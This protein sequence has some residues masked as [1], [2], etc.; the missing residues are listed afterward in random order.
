MWSRTRHY[1]IRT[2]CCQ[3]HIHCYQ[4]RT[5]CSLIKIVSRES[6]DY[7]LMGRGKMS[8][9]DESQSPTQSHFQS[10]QSH[11]SYC[12]C[13][14]R[15]HSYPQKTCLSP[16][17]SSSCHCCCCS[18]CCSRGAGHQNQI[19]NRLQ[20]TG[21]CRRN[22]HGAR[23]SHSCCYH[24]SRGLPRKSRSSRG[25]QT[26]CRALGRKSCC[27]RSPWCLVM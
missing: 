23:R 6:I 26:R 3:S 14:E 27:C 7:L 19:R 22:H 20:R 21:C 2:R 15:S 16:C 9:L 13:C 5:H 10:Y 4:S 8:Y 18:C 25:C 12:G 17:C 1:Q 11:K 24:C